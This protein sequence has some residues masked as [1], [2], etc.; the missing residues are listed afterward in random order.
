MPLVANFSCSQFS[1]TPNLITLTDTS[2][3]TDV[4]I[5]SRR[6]YIQSASGTFLVPTG[7]TTDYIVWAYASPS[8]T[9]NVLTQDTAASITVQWLDSSNAQ[10]YTKTSSFA[11]TAYNETFYYNLTQNQVANPTII[12]AN[13]YYDSKMKLRV[14]LDSAQQAIT[15]ASDIFAAQAALNR[16][17]DL[18]TNQNY[19]F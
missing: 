8:L 14:E 16:A 17:T 3:G 13:E 10:V 5:T 12:A 6:V 7:T 4:T 2:T 11:F 15:F 1:G 9:V 19:Y 18:V